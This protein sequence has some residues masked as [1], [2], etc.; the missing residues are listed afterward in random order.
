[1]SEEEIRAEVRAA[2]ERSSARRV[3]AK[4]G[5]SCETAV[6][7]GYGADVQKRTLVLAERNLPLLRT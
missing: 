5:V 6:R 4:L 3:G 1:M 2:I 7:L